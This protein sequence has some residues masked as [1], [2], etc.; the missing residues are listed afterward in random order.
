[1][2]GSRD[3]I[4]RSRSDDKPPSTCEQTLEAAD[5]QTRG[6]LDV[7]AYAASC[8]LMLAVAF[9]ASYL[10]ARRAASINPVRALRTK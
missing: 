10:P 5:E 4:V 2:R 7:T 6:D 3:S 8:L 1:M 9:L